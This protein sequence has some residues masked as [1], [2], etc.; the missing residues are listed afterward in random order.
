MKIYEIDEEIRILLNDSVDDDGVIDEE[1][2]IEVQGLSVE[3]NK[4]IL[5]FAKFLKEKEAEID[6]LKAAEKRIAT[7]RKSLE[8]FH[9]NNSEFLV[10]LID[11]KLSDAEITV[12]KRRSERLIVDE[13]LFWDLNDESS[14]YV[15]VKKTLTINKALLKSHLIGAEFNG[16]HIEE[17]YSLQIK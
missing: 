7:R 1:K 13:D 10:G 4:K 6:A 14:D 8:N 15:N 17:H 5:N 12:S 9:A 11:N 2:M 16:A 3:R